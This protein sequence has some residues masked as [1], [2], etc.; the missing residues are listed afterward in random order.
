MPSKIFILLCLS[1]FRFLT[2]A[3]QMP[4]STADSN[5]VSLCSV[6]MVNYGKIAQFSWSLSLTGKLCF[7]NLGIIAVTLRQPVSII[8]YV[9]QRWYQ[10]CKCPLLFQ[11]NCSIIY[12]SK[13]MSGK[14]MSWTDSHRSN[15]FQAGFHSWILNNSMVPAIWPVHRHSRA[16]T[17]RYILLE[18]VGTALVH[19]GTS[20]VHGKIWKILKPR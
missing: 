1:W 14:K 2:S 9:G 10:P 16:E 5:N 17:N 11:V 6:S 7:V 12:M 4:F 20:I 18:M 3:C 19:I 13:I 15:L 8:K